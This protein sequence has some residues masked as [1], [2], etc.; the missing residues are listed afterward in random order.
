MT[1]GSEGIINEAKYGGGGSKWVLTTRR[2]LRDL[3][4]GWMLRREVNQS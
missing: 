1:G 2:H 3:K 4:I